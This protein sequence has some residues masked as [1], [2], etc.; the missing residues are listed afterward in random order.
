MTNLNHVIQHILD[1]QQLSVYFTWRDSVVQYMWHV[2][3]SL[4]VYLLHFSL[5]SEIVCSFLFCMYNC[6]EGSS[7]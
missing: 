4:F 7:Q 3:S 2:L 5:Y 6:A 1:W